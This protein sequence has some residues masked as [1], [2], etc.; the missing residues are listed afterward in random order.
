MNK[1]YFNKKNVSQLILHIIMIILLFL[2]LYPLAMAFWN[3]FKTP[4]GFI[5]NKWAP[6]FPLRINNLSTGFYMTKDYIFN[7]LFVGI[8]GITGMLFFSS[9]ASFAISKTKIIGRKIMFAMILAIMMIPGVLTLVPSYLLHSGLG[10]YNSLFAL[11]IP[12]WTGG[13]VFAVFLL[14]NIDRKSTRLN[15]SHV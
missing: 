7:T 10:F 5:F 13:C 8:V 3:A 14:V 2:M 12:M 11:I 15:S 6:S 4:D 9:M 1:N